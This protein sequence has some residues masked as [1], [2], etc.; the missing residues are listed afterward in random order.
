MVEFDPVKA[1]FPLALSRS[2]L[3][4]DQDVVLIS[5]DL[6]EAG[7]DI[8]TEAYGDGRWRTTV[9]SAKY[10]TQRMD[11][12]QDPGR[13]GYFYRTLEGLTPSGGLPELS[14]VLV[15]MRMLPDWDNAERGLKCI[16]H[17]VLKEVWAFAGDTSEL[18]E[19]PDQ[20]ILVPLPADERRLVLYTNI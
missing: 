20:E 5:P 8:I 2:E 7:C 10:M 6:N 16:P 13:C 4:F 1:E 14:G 17:A 3:S 9:K 11:R 12:V 18:S 19:H 15:G